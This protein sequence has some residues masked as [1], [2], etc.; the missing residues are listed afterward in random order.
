MVNA[1]LIS[2]LWE[3]IEKNN[4]KIDS[5]P[6]LKQYFEQLA[7]RDLKFTYSIF[8]EL[9]NIY[10]KYEL[11]FPMPEISK[12]GNSLNENS[13]LEKAFGTIEVNYTK[14]INQDLTG[15]DIFGSKNH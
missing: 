1:A 4:L 2:T 10:K 13:S 8:K 7:V 15:E 9:F 12:L 6:I 5:S 3:K 11:D 14:S